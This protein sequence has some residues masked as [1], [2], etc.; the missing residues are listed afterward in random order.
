MEQPISAEEILTLHNLLRS[1][2]QKYLRIVSDWIDQDPANSNAYFDRHFA[3]MRLGQPQRAL[4][5][6][7]RV[8]EL[9][10]DVHPIVYMSRGE[11]HRHLREYARALRDFDQGEAVDPDKWKND[12]VFGLIFQADSHAHLGNEE[13]ALAYCARLPDDF[14]TPGIAGA[15]RGN[16]AEVAN[17]LRRIAA[18]ARRRRA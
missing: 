16:K 5:D 2:P 6:L 7:D 3:W 13:A 12:I 14:W 10:H 9:E 8:I 15:P 18:D 11:V 4:N 1:D 17:E